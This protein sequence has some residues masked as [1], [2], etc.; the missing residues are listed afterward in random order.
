MRILFYLPAIA[1]WWFEWI[2]TPML[3]T[4]ASDGDVAE[5]HLLVAP[6]WRHSGLSAQHV[7]WLQHTAKIHWHVID[8]ASSGDI[9]WN[10]RFNGAAVPGLLDH[11][12]AINADLTLVRSAEP[13]FCRAFPGT[14]RFITEG[15]A[16]PYATDGRWVV[17]EEEAFGRGFM[18]DHA[19]A[20][21]ASCAHVTQGLAGPRVTAAEARDRLALNTDR[22]IL[23]VPLQW[24]HPD[25]FFLDL[26]GFPTSLGLINA[27]LDHTDPDVVLAISDHPL[28][29]ANLD[30]SDLKTAL[31]A[32][33]DRVILCE[34]DGATGLLAACADVM[35]S[36]LSKSW[37]L[38]AFHGTPILDV[39]LQPA[40]AWINAIP[41]LANLPRSPRRADLPAADPQAMALWFGWHL[42]ARMLD[43]RLAL[44]APLLR[45]V[46]GQPDPDD[47]LRAR[48]AL[49][50]QVPVP[51]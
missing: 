11:I 14:V 43:P 47:F 5:I 40:A 18:P 23:A 21:A 2:I 44:L 6:P 42:G 8:P 38:A 33:P 29:R 49:E 28:N 39:G 41:G 32:M 22:P 46:A 19:K 4:L 3:R 7:A 37:S 12:R 34:Q 26:A 15:A 20:H 31:A 30:R 50:G 16:P 17:L 35:V 27:L 24:E 45:R 25:N 10:F 1:D 36:D 48:T 9:A 51:A 13:A